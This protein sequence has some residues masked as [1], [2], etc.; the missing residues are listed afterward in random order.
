MGTCQRSKNPT[1]VVAGNNKTSTAQAQ[2]QGK[3]VV[4]SKHIQEPSVAWVRCEEEMERWERA[5]LDRTFRSLY[6]V[7]IYFEN[8]G[9]TYHWRSLK[10]KISSYQNSSKKHQGF[11]WVEK[12]QMKGKVGTADLLWRRWTGS[13]GKES[14]E[15]RQ[16]LVLVLSTWVVCG[17]LLLGLGNLGKTHIWRC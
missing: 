10:I 15:L 11:V 14:K 8:F 1:W 2:C 16:H 4:F 5:W 17:H 3:E 12:V 13:W 9:A 7:G 6:I